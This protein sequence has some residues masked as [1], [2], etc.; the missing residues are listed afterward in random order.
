MPWP[1]EGLELGRCAAYSDSANDIPM[2]SLVGFPCAINPDARLRAYAKERGWQVRDYRARR[3][4]TAIGVAARAQ[5]RSSAP[6]AVSPWPAA[7]AGDS[8][9]HSP[10]RSQKKV[11]VR[12][13]SRA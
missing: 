3:R 7:P 13:T 2:L 10:C 5:V 11:L 12:R 8:S 9:P 1:S 4:N 6:S